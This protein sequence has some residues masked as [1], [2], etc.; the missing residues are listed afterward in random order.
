MVS[1]YKREVWLDTSS[2]DLVRNLLLNLVM[3]YFV[4]SVG[5]CEGDVA[6]VPLLI[7][8]FHEFNPLVGDAHAESVVEA[9]SSFMNGSAKR[10]QPRHL[11]DT[12]Q[13]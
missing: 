2:R 5:Q 13:S 9:T 6:H 8:Y 3:T 7:R 11:C 4:T 10:R 1:S 12:C